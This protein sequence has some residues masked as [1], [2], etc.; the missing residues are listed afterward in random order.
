MNNPNP[1]PQQITVE[2]LQAMLVEALT[3]GNAPLLEAVN[4]N[5]QRLSELEAAH[6][7]MA[8]NLSVFLTKLQSILN[9]QNSGSRQS[10][11]EKQLQQL[12]AALSALNKEQ[13]QLHSSIAKLSE[14]LEAEG[15]PA[16][17]GPS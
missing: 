11:L 6:R 17:D 15:A 2:V 1:R 13:A 3:I 16:L 14:Q 10:D 8:N 4:Q 12:I 9:K 5:S 7:D